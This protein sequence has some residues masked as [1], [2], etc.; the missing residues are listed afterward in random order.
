VV[1]GT[2]GLG[3]FGLA[4]Y[5]T[6]TLTKAKLYDYYAA[7]TI[8]PFEFGADFETIQI[9]NGRNQLLHGWFIKAKQPTNKVLITANGF[10]GRKE[11]CLGI[12]MLLWRHSGYNILM[13]DYYGY[14]PRATKT[15]ILTLGYNELADFQAGV[16]YAFERI[17]DALVGILGGSMGAAICIMAAAKD[18]RIKAVWA[19]S[20]FARL[21]QVV[22]DVFVN[23]T[24]LPTWPVIPVSEAM[25]KRRTG[26]NYGSFQPS[27]EIKKIAPRAIYITHSAGDPL[28]AV[29]HAHELYAAAGNPKELWIAPDVKEHCGNYFE[30]PDEYVQRAVKFFGEHLTTT[31]LAELVPSEQVLTQL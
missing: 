7:K 29:S 30:K 27:Q 11:D 21:E 6:N 17:P 18:T 4:S 23:T 2:S 1:L 9:D 3:A 13:F 12:A 25:F 15:D 20:A 19:D 26:Y 24:H 8:T 14:G 31:T 16:N 10:Q 5:L 28:I 22:K